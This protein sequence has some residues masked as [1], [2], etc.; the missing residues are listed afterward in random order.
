MNHIHTLKS[1]K[2]KTSDYCLLALMGASIYFLA[3]CSKGPVGMA[4]SVVI[5]VVS[6]EINAKGAA[7]LQLSFTNTTS[8][9]ILVGARSVIETKQGVETTNYS[10]VPMFVGLAGT[11]SVASD[12][13]LGA[14]NGMVV[15]LSPVN[16]SGA[17]RLEFVCFPQRKGLPGVVD[18]AT[19]KVQ[20][21]TDGSQ[22][23]NHLGAS[24]F[25][26]SP[27]IRIPAEPGAE[28]NEPKP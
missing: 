6:A 26:V 17:F 16:V 18:T 12:L 4:S 8:H 28:P 15:A 25:L 22:H 19:D 20:T 14:G 21:W 1:F 9:S 27:L 7:V 3:G 11:A 5:R 13:T 23:E 2:N 10:S 24:F